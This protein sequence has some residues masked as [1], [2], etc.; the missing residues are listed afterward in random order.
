MR[1][2]VRSAAV[3]L[4]ILSGLCIIIGCAYLYVNPVSSLDS[5]SVGN[6]GNISPSG[7]GVNIVT[8]ETSQVP[9][10]NS[11][12][13]GSDSAGVAGKNDSGVSPSKGDSLSSGKVY[14]PI[15][16]AVNDEASG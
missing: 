12:V 10:S 1:R 16:V 3:Y 5:V 15:P 14:V 8:K 13:G 9:G 7:D 2:N 6:N 11:E 4:V